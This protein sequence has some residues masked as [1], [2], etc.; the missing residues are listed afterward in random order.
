PNPFNPQTRLSFSLPEAGTASLDI[1]NL[2]GQKVKN[3]SAMHYA[4]GTHQIGFDGTDANGR[5][6]ASGVYYVRILQGKRSASYKLVLL[7]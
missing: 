7:K 6:L 3:L 4:R 1:Y 5:P 2:K